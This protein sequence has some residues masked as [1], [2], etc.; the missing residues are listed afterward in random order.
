MN[1]SESFD[2]TAS[3]PSTA[4]IGAPVRVR[5]ASELRASIPY[6]LGFYPERSVVLLGLQHDGNV[7]V[8]IRADAP[9]TAEDAVA[10]VHQVAPV[11]QRCSPHRVLVAY[12]DEYEVSAADEIAREQ[13]AS[14]AL[15]L[16][17]TVRELAPLLE[18]ELTSYGLDPQ[19][20]WPETPGMPRS[21]EGPVPQIAVA[22]AVAGRR[23]LRNRAEVRA[24]LEP[25]SGSVRRQ[26]REQITALE[27]VPL[28]R[29]DLFALVTDI[30]EGYAVAAESGSGSA[31]TEA[32]HVAVCAL[33]L[34]DVILRDLL[35]IV[36]A[37][38]RAWWQPDLWCR[39]VR[40]APTT[41]VAA[42]ATVAAVTAYLTGDGALA[43]SACDRALQHDP[44]YSLAAMVADSLRLGIRPQ[45]LQ[46]MLA[47]M[48]DPEDD[49][50][51]L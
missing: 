50:E 26:V 10:V 31:P 51:K 42:I 45:E 23:L 34:R 32:R 46:A 37:Q 17:E 25:I 20:I 22:N 9:R 28:A 15:R 19:F 47:A 43:Q 41:D 8:T 49:Q 27:A 16:Y 33:A 35:I 14:S 39:A 12:C 7:S 38:E 2:L 21:G 6:L 18:R 11:L 3:D 44:D 29:M 30:L 1:A 40:L 36:I 48:L 4:P 13:I 24:Q 5:G